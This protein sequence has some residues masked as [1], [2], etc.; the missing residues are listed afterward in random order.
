MPS[1]CDAP[2]PRSRSCS[3]SP[4]A[5]AAR[6]AASTASACSSAAG[7]RVSG[8]PPRSGCTARSR[9]LWTRRACSIRGRKC[10][11]CRV[12][13]RTVRVVAEQLGRLVRGRPAPLVDLAAR[14]E[15]YVPDDAHPPPAH[16]LRASAALVARRGQLLV[17]RAA[18]PALLLDL[19]QRRLLPRL[20]AVELSF[21]QR[22]VHV[23][24]SGAGGEGAAG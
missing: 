12:D 6:S 19:A 23:A 11:E 3:S 10:P 13:E 2:A 5:S 7:S 9:T 15:A 14:R 1:S 8:I 16:N 24:G 20:V 22:P 4:C 18:Q 21:R 17:Q